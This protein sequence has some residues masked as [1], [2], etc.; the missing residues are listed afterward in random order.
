METTQYILSRLLLFIIPAGTIFLLIR[1]L[2]RDYFSQRILYAKATELQKIPELEGKSIS[3]RLQAYERLSLLCERI[4][5]PNL[6]LR[7]RTNQM[8]N[9]D[10]RTAMLLAIQQEYEHNISQQIYVSDQLWQLL[11][12]ART[13]AVDTISTAY[14]AT[15]PEENALQ[16]A[17]KLFQ[18]LNEKEIN[19][20]EKVQSA[21]RTETKLLF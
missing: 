4:S 3:F 19:V 15:Q 17:E 5:I 14:A 8:T 1:F 7:L 6:L 11:Q 2:M 12:F 20:L 13:D 9:A 18:S 16:L 21:I 10:L